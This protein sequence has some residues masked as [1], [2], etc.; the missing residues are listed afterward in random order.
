MLNFSQAR[1]H[2]SEIINS[3]TDG[4]YQVETDASL[5]MSNPPPVIILWESFLQ[6]LS[7]EE[8]IL[9]LSLTCIISVLA[10]IGNVLTLCVVL[11]R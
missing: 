7:F 11:F 4:D 8:R 10:V 9:F 3:K 1:A 5:A 6:H 2:Y